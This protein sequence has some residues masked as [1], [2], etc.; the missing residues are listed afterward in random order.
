MLFLGMTLPLFS[1]NT[2]ITV[3]TPNGGENWQIGC[4]YVIQWISSATTSVRIDLYSNGTLTQ[5]IAQQ[6]PPTQNSYTWTPSYTIAP[7]SSYKI[8]VTSL[9]NS[10]SFDF[11]N[12][13]FTLSL[14]SIS[15]VSPNGGEVWAYGTTHLI[16]WSDN[17]C[18]NVRIELWK[19]GSFFSL[20]ASSTP[21]TGSFPWAITNSYPAGNDYKIK[22]MSQALNS[23]ATNTVFDFSDNF[24]TI[25]SNTNCYVTVTSPNGGEIWAVGST[26]NITWQSNSNYNVRIELWKN[27]TFYSTISSSS[28]N[29]GTLT[30][31]IPFSIPGGTTYKVKI[32]A[33]NSTASNSCFDFSNGNFS[34]L[35]TNSGSIKSEEVTAKMFPNPCDDQLTLQ[36]ENELNNPLVEIFDVTGKSVF[37]VKPGAQFG[38]E[39][40]RITTVTICAGY[41]LLL[42]TDGETIL[43]RNSLIIK[44]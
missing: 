34:I 1:Q 29:T 17:L 21:S 41:Y 36:F 12:A 35:S 44:H 11:S 28:P 40:I 39:P 9:S 5:T 3:V 6:I 33:I 8:K 14:G 18:E 20:L 15:V 30:W 31:S 7:G 32:L 13:N 10:A 23:G 42:V 22:I 19:G 2:G 4:T 43:M 24:F 16:T 38:S 37:S 25:G 26:H 27:G